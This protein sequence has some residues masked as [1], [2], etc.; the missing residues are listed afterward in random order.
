M[1]YLLYS[2]LFFIVFLVTSCAEDSFEIGQTCGVQLQ[3]RFDLSLTRKD[4]VDVTAEQVKEMISR[5]LDGFGY[6]RKKVRILG[7]YTI[8]VEIPEVT[9]K[10]HI[11]VIKGVISAST[12]ITFRLPAQDKNKMVQGAPVSAKKEEILRVE[13]EWE[14]YQGNLAAWKRKFFASEKQEAGEPPGEPDSVVW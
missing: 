2:G 4:Q 3:Y 12:K 8:M 5:R 1:K 11:N 10:K 14:D 6:K 13:K 9:A 7:K